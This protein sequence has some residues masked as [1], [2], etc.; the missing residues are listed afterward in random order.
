[1]LFLFL[2]PCFGGRPMLSGLLLMACGIALVATWALIGAGPGAALFARFGILGALA[3]AALVARTSYRRRREPQAAPA[4]D[5]EADA[6]R[7]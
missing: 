1:M 4:D 3:G 7:Q 2:L 5:R 6:G